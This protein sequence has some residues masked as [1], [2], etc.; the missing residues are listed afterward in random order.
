MRCWLGRGA[1][2]HAPLR[3]V[4]SLRCGCLP[5]CLPACC[6][7]AVGAAL[8]ARLAAGRAWEERGT[9]CLAQL[10]AAGLAWGGA[11]GEGETSEAAEV[12]VAAQFATVA[13][14]A[15]ALVAEAQEQGLAVGPLL[16]QLQEYS[17]LYCLCQRAYVEGQ[18]MVGCDVCQVSAAAGPRAP[19]AR[20]CAFRSA[21]GHT[22]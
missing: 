16:E 18:E 5:A 21:A 14:R 13:A 4:L 2:A 8:L 19:N 17:R 15:A 12:V 22:F 20:A 3:A 7:D 11:G 6:A 1:L 10:K 9:E